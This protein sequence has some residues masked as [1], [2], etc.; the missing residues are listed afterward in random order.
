ML[1]MLEVRAPVRCAGL[2]PNIDQ[3]GCRRRDFTISER[4][5][6]DLRPAWET[7]SR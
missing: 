6:L 1:G 5:S 7:I 4:P 3:E 2:G